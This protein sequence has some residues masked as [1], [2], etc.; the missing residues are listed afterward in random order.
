MNSPFRFGKIVE[1]PAFTDREADVERLVSNFENR[2]HTILI[3][4][5]RWGKSSLVWKAANVTSHSHSDFRFCFID[6]FNIRNESE[7]Y[8]AYAREIIKAT[9]GKVDEWISMAQSLLNRLQPKFS[10]GADPMNDFTIQFDLDGSTQSVQDILQLPDHVSKKKKFRVVV[11]LDE[12][13]NLSHF[14]DP[15]LFQRRLRSVWQHHQHVTYCLYG[16]QK[17]M[18]SHLFELK[19]MPFYKFGDV[20][21]LDKIDIPH[22]RTF[23]EKQFKRTGKVVSPRLA[24]KI[25]VWMQGHPSYVQQLSHMVWIRTEH[26]VDEK[27]L[28]AAVE[29]IIQQNSPLFEKDVESLSNTQV[30]FLS[31]LAEGVTTLSSVENLQKYRLGTS[32][33]VVK[34]KR[35]LE[36]KEIIEIHRGRPFF[37]DPLF[38]LWLRRIYL[39][40]RY[41]F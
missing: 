14:E 26:E 41:R 10:F 9:S 30:N 12:F 1:G 13:Q 7:F 17:S 36:K 8:A 22:W 16:S 39:K 2:I 18:L 6:L 40:D 27:I 38:E 33:N 31:A 35:V 5:R 21:Y 34:I 15:G 20:I 37:V 28:S 24:E 11:C 19:S 4:P 3:S 32:A 23:I 25:G 29:D